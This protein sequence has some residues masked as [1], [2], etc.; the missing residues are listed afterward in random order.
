MTKLLRIGIRIATALAPRRV[1]RRL[2]FSSR[3][4]V[5]TSVLVTA[6]LYTARQLGGLQFLEMAAFDTMVRLRPD[7]KPDPRLLIVGIT[8]SDLQ[9]WQ[10][11]TLSDRLVAKLI[12]QLQQYQPRVIGLDLYRDIPQP[13]G[14]AELVDQLRADNLVVITKLGGS[15]RVPPPPGVPQERVGFNDFLIDADGVIRRNLMYA[16]LEQQPL[17][18]FS[19][20]TSLS[21]FAKQNIALH[22]QPELKIGQAAFEPLEADAGGYQ[23]PPSHAQGWQVLLNYRSFKNVARQVTLTQ[24]LKQQ[25][26]PSWVKDKIV[27]IG[28]TAPSKKDLFS[29][30]Y[31]A[32][33]MPGVLVHAQMTSQIL[34]AVLDA[35]P[36]FWYWPQG[37]EV[38]WVWVWSLTGSVLAWHLKRPLRLGV[39]CAIALGGLVVICSLVF[40]QAGWI[41]LIPPAFAFVASAGGVLAYKIFYSSLHDPLTG[42]PNRLQLLKQLR[43]AKKKQA[44]VA[45][46]FV[47]LDRFKII[48]E[49]LGHQA[50]DRLL[51]LSQRRIEA[52]LRPPEQLARVGGDEF[53]IVLQID[54]ASQAIAVAK[55]LQENLALPFALNGQEICI[56]A[57]LGITF[58]A[59]GQES[60]PEELLRDAHTAM[61]RAKASGRNCYEIFT[62]GMY[63]DAVKRLQL[64]NDL[65]QAIARQEFQLC[66]QPIIDLKTEK[67]AGFEAL[68]RWL[69]PKRGFV[70]PGEFIP[71]AEETGLI[72]PLGEWILLEACR[73][74][75]DWHQQFP[76][77][78]ALTISVNLSSCQFV[79]PDLVE[80]IQQI[81]Q[82]TKINRLKLEITESAVME[83][84]EAAIA[85]MARLKALGITIS[86]DDFGTGYSS[87]SYLHQ[88]PADTLKVDQQ[89]VKQMEM[90]DRNADIVSTIILLAHQLGMDVIAEGIETQ[91]HLEALQA[92]ECEYGQGYFFSKPL[93]SEA[94]TALLAEC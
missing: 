62:E 91:A 45:V 42:L 70:S 1:N 79:Q 12:E 14:N 16:E 6:L 59:V 13:P 94:A 64:E 2:L 31:G 32:A 80:Q 49:S 36:L 92:L 10:Q 74:M 26:D 47:D 81:L 8:E 89:F 54:E 9:T 41:P 25:L 34:S 53:A 84:V 90:A 67:I 52:C 61:Y 44:L 58:A 7:K 38:L 51:I 55:R 4:I 19:L 56:T 66:Y 18:S 50:G 57:S 24:V 86:I 65:R 15:D 72:I 29:T 93:S 40:L 75:H 28:Y 17:Y 60:Q 85:L 35:Q 88:F 30:P 20:R 21:Y 33:R 23:M 68:V 78:P 87:L 46:L 3:L 83:N 82:Q 76:Q 27:L 71:L 73:Q 48:N 37:G 5:L 43:Q 22:V 39:A 69:S 63:T 11:S 77:H